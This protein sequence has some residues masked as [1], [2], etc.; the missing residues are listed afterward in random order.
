MSDLFYS[1][2]QIALGLEATSAPRSVTQATGVA[3]L[4]PSTADQAAFQEQVLQRVNV[5]LQGLR[6][7][8]APGASAYFNPTTNQMF[9][10]GRAFD[11]RDV[12]SALQAS[13]ALTPS[14][15][16]PGAGWQPL[17][18]RGFT[19]YLAGFSERRGTGELLARGGR[20]AVGGLIG[21]VGRGIEMLGAPETGA[22]IA[23]FGEA[24]TG[25]DE[26]DRQRSA[27]IQ[28]SNSLFNNIVD[29]A[30][31]GVPS[32]LTSGAAALAGGVAGGLVAGPAGAAAGAATAATLARA[33][34]IGAVGGLLATSFP[35]QLNTFYEAARD[36]RTPDGQPAYDVTNSQIQLQIAGGALA[37][38][39]LDV[40]APGRVAGSISRTLS[41]AIEEASQRAVTGLARAKSV[42]GAAVRSGLE[43]AGT[44][45][46][47][48]VVEQ[49]LFDPQFR[50]LL[51]A[52][53]W[54][55]LAPY[56]VE[57]YGENALIA[58]G[59]GALLGAGFGGAGRF[60]ETGREPRDILQN[61]GQQAPQ[62]R[63]LGGGQFGPPAPEQYGPFGPEQFG[64]P[65][66]EQFGPFGP[67]Q[68]GPAAP[69]QFGPFGRDQFGPPAPMQFGPGGPEQFG[70]PAPIGAR[71]DLGQFGPF[72]RDQFG[73]PA[74]MQF[75]P[76][77]PAQFGPP[78]PSGTVPSGQ[79]ALRRPTPPVQLGETQAGNQ[80]LA[81]RRQMELR[82]A[83]A[84]RAAQPPAPTAAERDYEAALAQA[85]VNRP[86]TLDTEAV[87]TG[88]NPGADNARRSV[89]QQ[90]NGLTKAQ[91]DEV[92]TGYG[93]D[94]ATFLARVERM[95]TVETQ[96]VRRQLNAI[97]ETAPGE[98]AIPTAL[99]APVA[100]IAPAL[101]APTMVQPVAPTPAAPT[102]P[103]GRAMWAG[104]DADIPVTVSAEA[105]QLGPDGRYY[106]RVSYEGRDSYVPADQLTPAAPTN[107]RRGR[108]R[109]AETGQVGQG[110][111]VERA[112]AD[113]GRAPTEAGGR[114]RALRRGAGAQAQAAQEVAPA[115]APAVEA[116]PPRPLE[117]PAAPVAA[118]RPNF[119]AQIDRAAASG[120]LLTLRDELEAR[121]ER[122]AEQ[123]R[124]TT[125]L[126]QAIEKIEARLAAPPVPAA[127]GV[128]PPTHP[129]S[130]WAAVMDDEGEGY[131]K[132]SPEA[133][134]EWDRLV[135]TGVPLSSSTAQQ[136]EREFPSEETQATLRK[137]AFA[138]KTLEAGTASEKTLNNA[139]A[140]LV[141]LSEDPNPQIADAAKEA[142]GWDTGR[143]S[144]T[145]WNT[146]TNWKNADGT[147]AR[148]MAP[149]R[150]QM[151]VQTFLSK[152][153]TK[154]KV[155]VVANQQELQRT[156]PALYARA[157]AARSQGDFATANAAGYAFGDGN[158]IIF[159]DRIANEQH[160]RF[161]LAHETFGHFGL[162]GILPRDRFDAA[163]ES[164]YDTDPQA[165][166][167]ADAAM[168]TRGLSKPEAVEE[169]L[170]DYASMLATSTVARVWNAIKRFFNALGIKSGD[171][172]TRYLLDQSR[173]YVRDGR[174]GAVFESAAVA[175]RLHD[176]E[177]GVHADGRYSPASAYSTAT[178]ARAYFDKMGV[179]P[180]SLDGLFKAITDRTINARAT[181][182]EFK[183]KFLRLP[184]FSA[185]ENPGSF[186]V[187]QLI[188]SMVNIAMAMKTRMNENLR[189]VMNSSSAT[190][191]KLSRAM[192]AGRGYKLANINKQV[193]RGPNLIIINAEGDPVRNEPEVEKLFKSGLLTIDQIREGFK[194]K[195]TLDDGTATE[196]T[197]T[198][199]GYK[200]F[201]EEDYAK[202]V[203]LRRTIL[204]A[205]LDLLAAE[206]LGMLANRKV[207][208]REMQ[209]LMKSKKLD[210]DDRAF[211]DAFVKKYGE[212]YTENPI[213]NA[214][215][216]EL[217]NPASIEKANDFLEKAHTAFLA[218]GTDLNAAIVPFFK[219][220]ADADKFIDQ[221][222]A[223]RQRRVARK[224]LQGAKA[225]TLQN[226]V[227]AL[228]LNSH[229]FNNRQRI[230]RRNISTGYVSTVREG[231]WQTRMQAYLNGKPVEVKDVH[232]ELLIYSQFGEKTD[233]TGFTDFLN[234]ELDGKTF[235]LLVRNEDGN[236][237]V[238]KVTLR[239]EA[240]AV[241][242]AV[243]TDPQLNL[244]QFLYGLSLF[245]IDVNPK[246]MER[247][248]T[249]LSRQGAGARGRLEFSQTPGYDDTK[250]IYAVSRYTEKMA[251]ATA[252][253]TI[254]PKL[255]ELLNRDLPETAALWNGNVAGVEQLR[256]EYA[257]VNADPSA[258][259][260]AKA[261][262]KGA[263]AQ[264]ENMLQ[265]TQRSDGVNMANSYYNAS[266]AAVSQL[267]GNKFVDESDFFADPL[268]ARIRA[269]TAMFQL[270]GS[271]AQGVLNS[272]SPY[273]N[274]MPYMATQNGKTG[275]GGGFSIGKVQAEYHRAY[276]KIGA[277]GIARMAMNDASFYTD[278]VN[279]PT[280]RG[281]YDLTAEE[282]RVMAQE[283]QSGKL[284]PAQNNALMGMARGTTTNRW[285]LQFM[286]KFMAPFNL[287]EQAARRAAFL[288][289][290]R[291]YRNRAQA[292][293]L[294]E[295]DAA[296]DAREKAV[297]SL[298]LTLG[299]YSVMNRPPAWRSGPTQF[300]Y[301]Y[302]TYPTTVIQTM[303]RLSR[304]GQLSMLGGL[305]LLSGVTGLPFAEDLEDLIDTLAQQLGFQ[306]GSIRAEIIR[307][308]EEIVPGWSPIILKGWINQFGLADVAARTGMGN[309]FPGTSIGLAGADVAREL[310]DILG[311]AAG[312]VS[313]VAGTARDLVTYPFSSTK[314]LEDIARNSPVTL[315]RMLGDTSA[316]L[317][318]GA[319]VDRRGYVVS[320]EMDV[321]TILTRLAGFYPERAASQYDI[322]RIA[323]RETD[324][325][326]EVV[327]AYRQA[328]IKATMRGDSQGARDIV[329]AVNNW[330]DGTRGTALEITRFLQ[331]SQRA[332]REAQ[333]GAGERA[334]R[335]APLAAREDIRDLVD[336]LTE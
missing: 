131:N 28:R 71:G 204:D 319:V 282:A 220:K 322:I 139:S 50:S 178:L 12:G 53:D 161:V 266:A 288:A 65:A 126:T 62:G 276:T 32:V 252:R 324:Y 295:R 127:E 51:T 36:A 93:D 297:M 229:D 174:Q 155:T 309:I 17:T 287:S 66:P 286:D 98:A 264:A 313:G 300:L 301:M 212:L 232:Q 132:L 104:P 249:R 314:T 26:F 218:N 103:P 327:A 246:V 214:V 209:P 329:E 311:P 165:R 244:Q 114:N 258:T 92:L 332:L 34:T 21:G 247:V 59:A 123:G 89:V 200:D 162:R 191:D 135:A 47:Q 37:T 95:P 237:E 239:A 325:Q 263:L 281:K 321:G 215:G 170:S 331:N 72:G 210:K 250:G 1:P 198:F 242:D 122:E 299:E 158:V 326:K 48:T 193:L 172:M 54:K 176:V 230:V 208:L 90:F 145:D 188:G 142:L 333:R 88:R 182:E 7:P 221:M 231:K 77:G 152:L 149:G 22:A 81:L 235:D 86:L 289:A 315:M 302:K 52:N 79:A 225:F 318:S 154:P 76:A 216:L 3:G 245:N 195:R 70:P 185:L 130:R 199:E 75:G 251:S 183:D 201:T 194:W 138:R 236:F 190:Q 206:Y 203:S 267:D 49:A 136:V 222:M 82:Q 91:Q 110:R 117:V 107:L 99:P 164:I 80:L 29:A 275:F 184:A 280:L 192:Y 6:A 78:A 177:S 57:R 202:Y 243:S 207:S 233:A 121:V 257:R 290:Y 119:D 140:E 285:A 296:N 167:A 87:V 241:L 120:E 269:Y 113:E 240:G 112:A 56:A 227:K 146:R 253:A 186:Q 84:Q 137:I 273:T 41:G 141:R 129:Q 211:I 166:A 163:M 156:N 30:I 73:P 39:L 16:P 305:W 197:D 335:A 169:Y 330:N 14:A 306:Q 97:A 61:Q 64:P 108:A 144:L 294:S 255:R 147:D 74:P 96:R 308:L 268:M 334:L 223:M 55:A 143:P 320:P 67:E 303:R 69:E 173:R 94:P 44:E 42:G 151:L 171:S 328:W 336:A 259:R 224:D 124:S 291:L 271:I 68:F 205:D 31:E 27:V 5:G 101:A 58:A 284:Q 109:A 111:V 46:L 153:A 102:I 175:Q 238:Q 260:E 9:A 279:N 283:I 125:E 133:R 23:G 10:G 310:G 40:I 196:I 256:K 18:Q 316:Y 217:P 118:Q 312:F 33:R 45:A 248:V 11:I 278:M 265:K 8:S 323:Q 160:L 181:F 60:I 19:D 25:Q 180:T 2:E 317:S 128:L 116:A 105:P 189:A 298:D 304:T 63:D 106:Q 100:E 85:T 15:P 234:K 159:T 115:P 168:D 35:Q 292:A 4:M 38:S 262:Y 307:H 83:E 272:I 13:Q 226:E 179:M 24:V 277:P 219:E 157:N 43:E 270:G 261:Y 148:P 293:G 187:N 228:F 134:R 150:V 213:T 274:W 254:R 20:A